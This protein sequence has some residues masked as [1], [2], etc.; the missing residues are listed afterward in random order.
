MDAIRHAYWNALGASSPWVGAWA[1]GL[2]STGHE[3]NNKFD[4]DSDGSV[5][6][7]GEYGQA[8]NSTMDLHNNSVGRGII[9]TTVLG[10]PDRVSIQSDLNTLYGNGD[11]WVWD[12]AGE[13]ILQKS[14]GAKIY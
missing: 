4:L 10:T 7:G 11:L 5:I 13:G 1:V 8:F 12:S 2:V 14:N 6:F 3:R 9:H